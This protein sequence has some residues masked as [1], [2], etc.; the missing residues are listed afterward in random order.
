MFDNDFLDGFKKSEVFDSSKAFDLMGLSKTQLVS[1]CMTTF[2]IIIWSFDHF[3]LEKTIE[4]LRKCRVECVYNRINEKNAMAV[5]EVMEHF[6]ESMGNK[7]LNGEG[8]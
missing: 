1:D 5:F 7:G 4:L 3:G 6:A 8:I 2:N